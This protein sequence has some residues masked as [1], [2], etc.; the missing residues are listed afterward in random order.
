MMMKK[1]SLKKYFILLCCL[2]FSA[3]VFNLFLYPLDLV[4]GGVNGI[5]IL[6]SHFLNITPAITIWGISVILLIFSFF[7]LDKEQTIASL[8]STFLYPFFVYITSLFVRYIVIDL[9]DYIL[10]SLIV[11]IL[12]GISNGILYKIGF[13]TGGLNIISQLL[14]RYFHIPYSKTTFVINSIIVIIGGFVFGFPMVLYALIII[15]VNSKVIDRVLLGTSKSK[16]FYITTTKEKQIRKYIIDHL[17]HSVTIFDVKG[18]FLFNRKKVL[19]AVV[20]SRDYFKLTEGIKLIDKDA[21]FVACN[22][23]EVEGGK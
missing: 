8:L 11:G 23:Y 2:F 14:Y 13:S 19:L 20:P 22:A 16:A 3:I 12:L 4:T 5:A 15:F 10:I 9:S 21:F 6:T 1:K 18:G 17:H 7:L